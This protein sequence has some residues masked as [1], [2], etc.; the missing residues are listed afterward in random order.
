MPSPV[1]YLLQ[2]TAGVGGLVG[3][4]NSADFI[5]PLDDLGAGAVNTTLLR[6]A[7][8]ATFTRA[9]TA[10]TKLST[11]LWASVASGTARSFYTG[12]N[13]A[14]GTFAGYLA[15]GQRTNLCLQSRDL[16]NAS[17]TKVNTTGAKDQTGIDGVVNSASSLTCTVNGGTCLQTIT[18]AATDSTLSMFI[19]IITGTGTITI[20][21]GASTSEISGQLNSSTYTQVSLDATVLNPAIG[22]VM[23]T[24]G[25]KIAIDMVQFENGAFA[26]TPIPT[27]T[28]AVTRNSDTLNYP[29]AGNANIAQGTVYAEV[30]ANGPAGTYVAFSL[31]DA[32]ANNIV[33]GSVG[34]P[35]LWNE[36]VVSGGTQTVGQNT[37]S[38]NFS[39]ALNK[40]AL[41]Y[42]AG[43]A[44]S[45]VNAGTLVSDATVTP[46]ASFTRIV[47]GKNF[48]GGFPMYSGIKNMRIW[49]RQL[50]DAQLTAMTA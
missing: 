13:T 45:V 3:L 50:S 20:Q 25:D 40:V 23:G 32:T 24:S 37:T 8:P 7:G 16:S 10:W 17:W 48:N 9:T 21:Q 31:D 5:L 18:E 6:G 33:Q 47:I 19:K 42:S 1:H 14:G 2:Q 12:M 34:S 30:V 43:S 46:P 15:E 35:N 22:I 26:S 41:S 4:M 29:S 44:S 27:T 28:V 39:Q 49:T 36:L 38:F 11:G